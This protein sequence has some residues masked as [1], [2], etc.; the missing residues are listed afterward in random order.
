MAEEGFTAANTSGLTP[1]ELAALNRLLDRITATGM[2][3][4]LAKLAIDH[5]CRHWLEPA[6]AAG[7]D[8]QRVLAGA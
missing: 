3:E 8:L 6:G 7:A 4:H 1:G 2:G 5:A